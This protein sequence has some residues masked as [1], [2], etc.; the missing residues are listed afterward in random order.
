MVFSVFPFRDKQSLKGLW[1]FVGAGLIIY[2]R[3]ISY[4]DMLVLMGIE[5]A[6]GIYRNNRNDPRH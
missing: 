4:G 3:L 6:E 2:P 5:R 1:S